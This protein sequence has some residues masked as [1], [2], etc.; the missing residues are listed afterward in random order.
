MTDTP[1]S[2]AT[3]ARVTR[4]GRGSHASELELCIVTQM[5]RRPRTAWSFSAFIAFAA[6]GAFWGVWGASVPQVQDQAG[7]SDGQLGLALLFVGAGAL[8]GD[9]AGGPGA[10]PLGTEV[11]GHGPRRPRCRRRRAGADR[12]EPAGLCAGL[13]LVGA[14][15]GATDVAM[16]AV[17]GRAEKVAGRPVITRAH[18]VFSSLVVLRSLGHR[19][20]V[21]PRRCRSR[22]RSSRWPSLS[23]RRPAPPCVAVDARPT[24]RAAEDARH[25][26]APPGPAPC[27]PP[28]A[29]RRARR[30]RVRQ[31]E[32]PPELERRLRP[33]RAARA[34]RAWPRS[35]R[36]SSRA[37]SRSPGSSSAASRPRTPGPSCSAGAL[38][39]AAGTA[40]I[41]AAPILLVAALGLALAAAGTAV[42]FPT[43]IGIV[44]RSVE[45]S[46]RGRATSIVTTVSYLGFLLGPGLRRAVG[47]RRRAARGHD[48]RRGTRRRAHPAR[49]A[50]AARGR[51]RHAYALPGGG[52][53][54][55]TV[56]AC[57]VRH[58]RHMNV[59]NTPQLRFSSGP[60]APRHDQQVC[61]PVEKG[62]A[63][64]EKDAVPAAGTRRRRFARGSRRRPGPGGTVRVI[65]E[66]L[67]RSGVPPLP[68]GRV[69]RARLR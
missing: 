33:R 64:V 6:F 55:R 35:R 3:C 59:A 30:A 60:P 67:A 51:R 25:A 56:S 34:V 42:L 19:P 24:S 2:S 50:G 27:R 38:A 58:D 17:A 53:R 49:A 7:V 5:S 65:G 68:Y 57:P 11:R 14:S 20:G 9:A 66:G 46:R 23:L 16:N 41:A 31:R 54:R 62:V 28:R 40:V 18:G 47:R 13:A 61:P 4:L 63:G 45:E 48:L 8:P 36:R 1:A 26:E 44:S 15:S 22:C 29:H 69:R 43:L 39:A 52:R 12:G 21:R 32:R 37:R 10:R